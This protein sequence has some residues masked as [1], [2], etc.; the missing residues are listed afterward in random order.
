MTYLFIFNDSPYGS[1][2]TYNGL[3]LLASLART[4]ENDVRA[5]LL[6]DGVL[7]GLGQPKPVNAF[8]NVQE[9]LTQAVS[10]GAQIGVCRTCLEARGIGDE[11]LLKGA[12][13]STLDELTTWTEDAEK[14]LTF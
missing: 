3:R 6:G 9:L 10:L 7:T 5:F 4:R 13:R 2:R 11:M 8:Y 1:Q 14:V 12:N